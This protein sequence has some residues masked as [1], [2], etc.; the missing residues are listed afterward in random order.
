M[1]AMAYSPSRPPTSQETISFE[2]A[3][4]AVQVHLSPAPSTGLFLAATFFCFAA[5]NDQISST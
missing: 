2:F 5:V 3:S 4:I 1:N